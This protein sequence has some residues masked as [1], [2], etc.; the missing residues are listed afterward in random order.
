[1][2]TNVRG[3]R[4]LLHDGENALLVPSDDPEALATALRRVLDD[5]GLRDVLRQGALRAA[6]GYTEDAMVAAYRGL[7]DKLLSR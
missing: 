7:Y 6:T 5:E 4:E 3:V 2:A 1:M